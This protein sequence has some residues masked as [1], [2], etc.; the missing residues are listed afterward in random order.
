MGRDAPGPLP[1]LLNRL[2]DGES[3]PRAMVDFPHQQRAPLLGLLEIRDVNGNAAYAHDPPVAVLFG[4]RY[5][6]S[7]RA[8]T[9]NCASRRLSESQLLYAANDAWAALKVYEALALGPVR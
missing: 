6:K 4:K 7:K 9:S 2:H 1:G 3:I 5:L 8:A